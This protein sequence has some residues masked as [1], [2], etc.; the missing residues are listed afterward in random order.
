MLKAW[1]NG[2]LLDIDNAKVSIFDRGFL[3]GDGLFETMR[4]YAGMVFKIDE[5]LARLFS[6]LKIMKIKPPYTK[7]YIKSVIYKSLHINGLS[8]AY[9]RLAITRGEGRFGLSYS[10]KFN[11]NVVIVTKEFGEYPE[12]M[13]FN[14][15]SAKVVNIRQN[16]FSPVSKI[17]S[18]NFLNNILA[19]LDAKDDDFDEAILMNTKGYIAEGSTSNIFLVKG[20]SL[21]TPTLDTGILAGVTRGIIVE[22]ARNLRI[23]VREKF[24]TYRELLKADEVFL[25]NSLIEVLPVTRMDSKDISDG[26]VGDLTK[27]LRISYQ[28]Q[29]IK[30]TIYSKRS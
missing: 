6:S 8:S 28:K 27:L 13:Y 10:D 26:N 14:G 29:V 24:V 30:E 23:K 20:N 1:I 11:P 9:I 7:K 22:I 18:L 4:S 17:K 15:I 16:Q 21:I 12:N 19:R 5:H 2:R 25:T 3:Y